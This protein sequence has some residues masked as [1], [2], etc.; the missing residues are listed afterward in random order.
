MSEHRRLLRGWIDKKEILMVF[1]SREEIR[2]E[3]AIISVAYVCFI[4]GIVC[5]CLIKAMLFPANKDIDGPAIRPK[6]QVTQLTMISEVEFGYSYS[7]YPAL[8]VPI[9]LQDYVVEV[10][11]RDGSIPNLGRIYVLDP[12]SL[13]DAEVRSLIETR[14]RAVGWS[15]TQI[16]PR[17][18]WRWSCPN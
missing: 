10:V 2:K 15:F 1:K 8:T 6:H 4:M 18:Q 14:A 16:S 3:M 12:F 9:M 7:G 5:F 17:S 11:G 13:A